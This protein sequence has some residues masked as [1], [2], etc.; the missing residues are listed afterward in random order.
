[1][2]A[3]GEFSKYIFFSE[4]CE[5]HSSEEPLTLFPTFL[6]RFFKSLTTSGGPSIE[7][8][9]FSKHLTNFIS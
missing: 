2:L 6:G 9:I 7:K 8:H 5:H 3:N 1:M 4:L